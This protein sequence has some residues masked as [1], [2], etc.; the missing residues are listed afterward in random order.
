MGMRLFV[1]LPIPPEL[2]TALTALARRA[3]IPHPRYT[4]PENLH[5]T[6]YFLG[7]VNDESLAALQTALDRVSPPTLHLRIA[8]LDTFPRAGVLFATV[9]PAPPLLALQAQVAHAVA[10]FAPRPDPNSPPSGVYHPHITLARTRSSLRLKAADL[11]RLSQPL[12]FT[13]DHINLYRSRPTPSG[14]HYEILRTVP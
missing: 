7:A 3:N 8:G 4:T 14:S 9:D 5:I 2:A 1:G 6:L 10:A 13:A 11:P 12:R